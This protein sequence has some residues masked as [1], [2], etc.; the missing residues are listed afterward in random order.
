M[1]F[2]LTQS[3]GSGDIVPVVKYDGRAGRLSRVDRADGM[4]TPVDITRSFRAILDL[5]N[6][7]VGWMQFQAGAAPEFT[8]VKLGD[9]MPARPTPD[10]KQGVRVMMLLDK[11][12]GR[13]GALDL[14]ELATAARVGVSGLDA[15]HDAYMAAAESK[16]GKLPVVELKD[17]VAV[18]SGS[19]AQKSTN[20]QP[21]FAIIGWADRPANLVHVPTAQSG[22]RAPTPISAAPAPLT[23]APPSTGSTVVAPPPAARAPVADAGLGDF[24]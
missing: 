14:R 19:G 7:E 23:S 15:L 4:N 9:P 13:D 5:Q 11:G 22:A 16:A 17:T 24:G 18:T 3:S 8:L 6:V 12:C 1:G 21:V 10:H 2:G 20:Y